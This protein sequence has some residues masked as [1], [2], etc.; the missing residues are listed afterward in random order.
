MADTVETITPAPVQTQ[1]DPVLVQAAPAVVNETSP[2][3][4]APAPEATLIAPEKPP[5]TLLAAPAPTPLAAPIPAP[6]PAP[7]PVVA[8]QNTD[9]GQS[10]EPAPPPTYEPF[11]LPENTSLDAA[12]VSEFTNILAA[13]EVDGKADHGITQQVGQKLVDFH[14]NELKNYGEQITKLIQTN[15]EK[16][17]TTWKDEIIADP[18]LGGAHLQSTVQAAL[19]FIRTHGGSEEEQKEFRSVMEVTGLGN[20]KAV[21]RL[22]AN[23]QTALKEGSPLTANRPLTVTKSRVA[24]MYGNS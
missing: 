22:L 6:T 13:L 18:V 14:V 21:I 10:A 12:K 17:R 19:E 2:I 8:N 1:V 3:V 16:Q 24:T 11:T 23:A 5:E 9:G 7:E 15:F 20:N 4:L